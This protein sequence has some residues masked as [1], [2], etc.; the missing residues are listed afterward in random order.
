MSDE[1]RSGQRQHTVALLVALRAEY[2]A[3][4]ASPLKHW[5]QLQ[6]RVRIAARTSESAGQ[7]VSALARSLGLGAPTKARS[8][9]TTTLCE[10]VGDNKRDN[11]A[12]LDQVEEECGLLMA[13]A[14]QEATRRRAARDA[15]REEEMA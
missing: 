13:L 12:F 10:L 9:A 8:S 11:A 7:W 15:A 1:R 4:G 6:D 14:V 2:L 3:A 5:D